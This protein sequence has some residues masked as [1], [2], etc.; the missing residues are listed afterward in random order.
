MLSDKLTRILH[1]KSTLTAAQI[2]AMTEAEGWNWVYSHASPHK[3]KDTSPAVCFT[4]FSLPDKEEL[5]KLATGA[6][7]RVVSG[8]SSL[9]LLLCAGDNPGPVKLE[10]AQDFGI[11]MKFLALSFTLSLGL[12]LSLTCVMNHGNA[13]KPPPSSISK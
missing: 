10:K 2:E 13:C 6:G 8:V 12:A 3:H 7:L 4:G 1:A 11:P 9:L 5:S